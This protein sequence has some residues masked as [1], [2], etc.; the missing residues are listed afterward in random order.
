MY[1]AK[2]ACSTALHHLLFF[3]SLTEKRL[4]E[5]LELFRIGLI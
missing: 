3:H 2:S 4:H 1:F 5:S